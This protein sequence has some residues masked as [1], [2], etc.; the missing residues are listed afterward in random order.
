MEGDSG[1]GDDVTR[2]LNYADR[3]PH[4]RGSIATTV[5]LLAAIIAD[6]SLLAAIFTWNEARIWAPYLH[7][8]ILCHVLL[9]LLLRCVLRFDVTGG[10]IPARHQRPLKR[11][12]RRNRSAAVI[13]LAPWSAYLL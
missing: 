4:D 8:P 13:P 7:P 10:S 12:D 11:S 1:A 2:T 3:M 5:G 6:V 9:G